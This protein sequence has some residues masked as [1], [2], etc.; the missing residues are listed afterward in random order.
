MA[1]EQSLVYG[2]MLRSVQGMM[3]FGVPHRGA[4]AAFWQE[5]VDGL[6]RVSLMGNNTR[7]TKSVVGPLQGNSEILADISQQFVQLAAQ[8]HIRTFYE[9][10]KTFGKLVFVPSH[11]TVLVREKKEG[12]QK[13][14]NKQKG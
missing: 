3:F 1:Q 5:F 2:D 12:G 11:F 9:G 10:R 14:S 13:R 8:L 4:D 7:T 6:I